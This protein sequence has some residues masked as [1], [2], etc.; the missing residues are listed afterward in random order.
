MDNFIFTASVIMPLFILLTLG[1][2]L[3]HIGVFTDEYVVFT[4]KVSFKIFLPAMLFVG[5]VSQ[6]EGLVY[7]LDVLKFAV[8]STLILVGLYA[9]IVPIIEKDKRKCGSIVQ[10]MFRSMVLVFGAPIVYNIYGEAGLAPMAMVV[11]ALSLLNSVLS[12]LLF[13]YF[14]NSG[15]AFMKTKRIL[16]DVIVNPFIIAST[17]GIA[18]IVFDIRIPFLIDTTLNSLSAIAAPLALLAVGGSFRFDKAFKNLK[19]LVP[20]VIARMLLHPLIMVAIAVFMG[21][22]GSRL[23]VLLINFGS[24]VATVTQAV[25][26]EMGGDSELAGQITVLTT[27]VSCFSIFVFIYG[28]ATLNLL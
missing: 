28:L 1:Y 15:N 16:K 10:A 2:F 6:R 27:F 21:F 19:Y 12:V 25:A 20:V 3:R 23:V 5:I 9:I 24:P 17:I 14:G 13:S 18:V 8:L 26:Q 11:F 4:N 22:Q 7:E